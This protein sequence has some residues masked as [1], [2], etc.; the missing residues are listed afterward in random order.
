V[1]DV[2]NPTLSISKYKKRGGMFWCEN[3]TRS[4]G[5]EEGPA[6]LVV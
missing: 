3:L 5:R 2:A 6:L 4:F 1:S